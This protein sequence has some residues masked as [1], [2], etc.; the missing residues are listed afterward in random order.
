MAFGGGSQ[1]FQQLTQHNSVIS[2]PVYSLDGGDGPYPLCFADM[3]VSAA[4]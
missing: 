4:Q 2:Q 1:D 3:T